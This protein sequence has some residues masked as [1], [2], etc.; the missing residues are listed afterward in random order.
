[1]QINPVDILAV[2]LFKQMLELSKQLNQQI[3][4]TATN[5]NQPVKQP[6]INFDG[7]ISIFA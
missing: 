5:T 3:L 2:E 6:P 7:K 1:M 4:Q